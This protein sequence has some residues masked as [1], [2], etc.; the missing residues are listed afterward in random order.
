MSNSL[1]F[2]SN[3]LVSVLREDGGM[4]IPTPG[5]RQE[6]FVPQGTSPPF[7]FSPFPLPSAPKIPVRNSQIPL[8]QNPHLELPGADPKASWL[9][10]RGRWGEITEQGHR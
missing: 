3:S 7:P 10:V 6:L 8:R 4:D 9:R 5:S 2:L 1:V